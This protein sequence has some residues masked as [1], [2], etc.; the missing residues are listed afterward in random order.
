MDFSYYI[1]NKKKVI[2]AYI[3]ISIIAISLAL[4]LGMEQ[5]EEKKITF[6]NLNDVDSR[7]I[8]NRGR[9]S[10]LSQNYE[11][12]YTFWQE[13]LK[14]PD[15]T[16]K[17]SLYSQY[18]IANTLFQQATTSH[19]AQQYTDALAKYKEAL[20]IYREVVFQNENTGYLGTEHQ[21]ALHNFELTLEKVIL[22]EKMLEQQQQDSSHQKSIAEIIDTM[23]KNEQQ[24]LEY[25]EKIDTIKNFTQQ[26]QT[27]KFIQEIQQENKKQLKLLQ[28]KIQ[29]VTKK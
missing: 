10:Y 7:Q 27:K 23:I 26:Q 3:I 11:D 28:E 24:I 12:A 29:Q 1:S 22:L 21:D 6:T 2:T 17:I 25:T 18:N 15:I 13:A 5:E 14:R 8:Y 9:L 4:L 16:T 20:L 19:K